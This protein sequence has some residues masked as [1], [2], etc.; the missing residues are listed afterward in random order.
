MYKKSILSSIWLQKKRELYGGLCYEK[1]PFLHFCLVPRF[2]FQLLL[3][4]FQTNP[5]YLQAHTQKFQDLKQL[6]SASSLSNV[7]I[8]F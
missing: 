8:L 7:T 2:P 1:S 5:P 4:P 3:N 6:L